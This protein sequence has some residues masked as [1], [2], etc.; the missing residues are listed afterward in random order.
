M[1]LRFYAIVNNIM[2]EVWY[3][4]I[5]DRYYIYTYPIYGEHGILDSTHETFDGAI[6]HMNEIA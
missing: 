2:M 4:H 3:N 5:D 6:S 1:Q